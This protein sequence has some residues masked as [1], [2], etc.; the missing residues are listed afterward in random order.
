MDYFELM[1]NDTT[2]EIFAFIDTFRDYFTVFL[3]CKKWN[4]ILKEKVHLC[5]SLCLNFW[6]NY[7]SRLDASRY[8]VKYHYDEVAQGYDLAWVQK[9]SQKDWVWFARQFANNKIRVGKN[10]PIIV[11]E[12]WGIMI[13]SKHILFGNI[14]TMSGYGSGDT[15]YNISTSSRM[16]PSP[17]SRRGEATLVYS[18]GFRKEGIWDEY[19]PQTDVGHY[20]LKECLEK[21]L[22]TN[23]I[24][25]ILPQYMCFFGTWY[26]KYCWMH[27]LDDS[28]GYLS[29][30]MVGQRCICEKCNK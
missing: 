10:T 2:G 1:P 18:D 26:C 19:G 21:G 4:Q 14:L 12:G 23:S 24:K 29:F 28:P 13:Y 9:E 11:G 15:P 17:H 7:K 8:K 3:V 27:C 6:N 30:H 16:L 22:C 20:K 5:M 25:E